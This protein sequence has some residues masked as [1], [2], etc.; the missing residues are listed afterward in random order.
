MR[1]Q[2][3]QDEGRKMKRIL[4]YL[5]IY[6]A[7]ARQG[8]EGKLRERESCPRCSMY[9]FSL[10][11]QTE[12]KGQMYFRRLRLLSLKWEKGGKRIRGGCNGTSSDVLSWI[13]CQNVQPAAINQGCGPE[14]KVG[15]VGDEEG[16]MKRVIPSVQL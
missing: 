15:A 2:K 7:Q 1:E 14:D 4:F 12:G 5:F 13:L 9:L 10:P 8:S 6:L 11:G 16:E 3:S